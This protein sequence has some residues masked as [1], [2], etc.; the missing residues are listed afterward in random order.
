[1]SQEIENAIRTI[2]GGC[3]AN[4]DYTISA[5]PY[6]RMKATDG[7]QTDGLATVNPLW[8]YKDDI[9]CERKNV[10]INLGVIYKNGVNGRL[11]KKELAS[12]F[13]PMEMKGKSEHAVPHKN[14]CV[15]DKSGES[16]VRYMPM[17]NKNTATRF[18]LNGKDITL[19]LKPFMVVKKDY[20]GRQEA[21]GLNEDEQLKWRTLTISNIDELRLNV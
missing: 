4:V 5:R 21:K 18:L 9:V 7:S 17:Q 6:F 13:K 19:A 20:S 3:F 10:Q 16:L 8:G 12:T 1:M 15:S 2:N 14:I 11:E